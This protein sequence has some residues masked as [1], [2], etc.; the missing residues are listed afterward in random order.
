MPPE[1]YTNKVIIRMSKVNW[2]YSSSRIFSR[3]D[4][5]KNRILTAMAA[6]W[7]MIMGRIEKW[8]LKNTQIIIETKVR[9]KKIAILIE[10]RNTSFLLSF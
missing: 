2:Q 6:T 5:G 4:S 8:M 9:V 10:F 1:R 7:A 3:L